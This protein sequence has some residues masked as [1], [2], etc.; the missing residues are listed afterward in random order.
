MERLLR[1]RFRQ[2]VRQV[3]SAFSLLWEDCGS[4]HAVLL[5]GYSLELHKEP[6]CITMP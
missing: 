3:L 6:E 1:W 5:L 4:I 2:L